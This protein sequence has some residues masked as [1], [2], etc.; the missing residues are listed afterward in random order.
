MP[1]E[2]W[3]RA[4]S[5]FEFEHD[6]SADDWRRLGAKQDVYRYFRACSKECYT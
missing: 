5:S 2:T 1:N 4:I 6:W 3:H